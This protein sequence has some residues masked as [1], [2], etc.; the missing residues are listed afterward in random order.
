M[1]GRDPAG[2]ASV[3]VQRMVGV[4]ALV[5]AMRQDER[6]ATDDARTAGNWRRPMAA[7]RLVPSVTETPSRGRSETIQTFMDAGAE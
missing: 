2:E 1:R 7:R 3:T 5:E 6:S 4:P